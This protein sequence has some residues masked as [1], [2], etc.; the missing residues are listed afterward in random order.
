MKHKTH[1]D[2][3]STPGSR[4]RFWPTLLFAASVA[5][6]LFIIILPGLQSWT[7]S[8]GW[9]AAGGESLYRYRFQRPPRGSITRDLE[10]EIGFYHARIRQDPQGG[11]DR[12][13]L[14]RAYFRMGRATGDVSWYLLAEQAARQSIANF[15]FRP[16]GAIL[17]LARVAESRHDFSEA[18]RLAKQASGVDESRAIMVTA[19]LAMGQV[20]DADRVA[21][22]L[23][24]ESPVLNSYTLR[25]LVKLARGEEEAAVEDFRQALAAE[26]PGEAGSSAWARMLLGRLHFKRGRLALARELYQEALRILPQ[27]PLGLV[28]LS[29]LETRLGHYD[30]AEGLYSQVVT[31]S[32]ASPNVFDHIVLR[33]KA[34]LKELEGDR[35][36]AKELWNQAEARLR[37][38]LSSFGHRR[39]LARVLLERGRP[40]DLPEALSLMQ[41][42]LRIRQDAET[43]DILAWGLSRT[44]R[45]HEAQHAM[46]EALRWGVRDPGMVYRAG[47]IE[48]ALGNS[49]QA[50]AFF[51]A[52]LEIDP[53]FDDQAR[54]ASGLGY[55]Y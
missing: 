40:E 17:V 15:P 3:Q 21:D 39:E 9:N 54:R 36:Q 29:E 11:M 1:H 48:A 14:A 20:D 22:Q 27:Y 30:A 37:Q 51:R 53:N 42:E 25:A 23:V 34:R 32:R 46:R 45:W 35:E 12:A 2:D 19:Y 24:E 28:N 44:G 16:D 41:T 13:A 10:N 38:D 18:I 55:W 5:G 31:I 49:S 26:E 4:D 7:G 6:L 33:G 8:A 47:T 50:D 43:Y 52:S